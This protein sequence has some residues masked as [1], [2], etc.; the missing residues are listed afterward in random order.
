MCLKPDL[1]SDYN[2]LINIL[3]A[4]ASTLILL[5]PKLCIYF[6]EISK[7]QKISNLPF[8][9]IPDGVCPI[10]DDSY[11]IGF[12]PLCEEAIRI[13]KSSILKKLSLLQRKPGSATSTNKISYGQA[14]P[15]LHQP[16][17]MASHAVLISFQNAERT[18]WVYLRSWCVIQFHCNLKKSSLFDLIKH[19]SVLYKRENS[20]LI[21]RRGRLRRSW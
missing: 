8:L 2:N 5:S 13:P 16:M 12:I 14:L 17:D 18:A 10:D 7:N 19:K 9:V 4:V 11:N 6:A 21:L 20:P 1:S 3:V 15:R